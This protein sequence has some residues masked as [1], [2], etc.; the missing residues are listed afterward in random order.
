MSS[1]AAQ[2]ALIK[3]DA[4]ERAEIHATPQTVLI[5]DVDS[6]SYQTLWAFSDLKIQQPA[7][8]DSDPK[9]RRS[10]HCVGVLA[11]EMVGH[12]EDGGSNG[13]NEATHAQDF[14]GALRA[15]SEVFPDR[16]WEQSYRHGQLSA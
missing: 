4:A 15:C 13:N 16:H 7:E 9:Q 1:G 12:G 6:E 10:C 2:L 8:H 5:G 11:V 14:A 3:A